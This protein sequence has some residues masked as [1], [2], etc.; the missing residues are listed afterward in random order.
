[1]LPDDLPGCSRTRLSMGDPRS[2][3][4]LPFARTKS[5]WSWLPACRREVKVRGGRL[6]HR[7][8]GSR[9]RPAASRHS[10]AQEARFRHADGRLEIRKD[11]APPCPGPCCRIRWSRAAACSHFPMGCRRLIAVARGANR[12]RWDR[13]AADAAQLE[14]WSAACTWTAAHPTDV[15]NE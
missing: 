13:P 12:N 6:K 8:E 10:G 15:T 2:N 14:I 7:H 9:L 11:L 5:W 3:A 1:M 4:A